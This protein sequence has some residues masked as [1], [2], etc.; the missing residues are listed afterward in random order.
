MRDVRL[1]RRLGEE[2]GRADLGDWT[3]RDNLVRGNTAACRP[4]EDIPL[5]LSGLGIAALGT[6]DTTVRGNTVEGNRPSLDAPIAGGIVLGSASSVGGP[7][8]IA[9]TVRGNRLG[10]NAPADLVTDGGGERN[11]VAGN[12]CEASVPDGLCG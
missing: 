8:P 7:D 2:E 1:D 4:S 6:T 3:I 10:G 12:R 11:R 5:P 9:T